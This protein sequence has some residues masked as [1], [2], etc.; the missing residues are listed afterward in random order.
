MSTTPDDIPDIPDKPFC[1]NDCGCDIVQPDW[2]RFGD[3]IVRRQSIRSIEVKTA[4]LSGD[5][6]EGYCYVNLELKF[7]GSGAPEYVNLWGKL[8][9]DVF[10]QVTKERRLQNVL[11]D[12]L[13]RVL[14][15]YDIR[16][17]FME[18]EAR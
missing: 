5:P 14:G 16:E 9:P 7:F 6:K 12:H 13:V 18:M 8:R 1:C 4:D 17:L 11:P 10:A 15:G 2:L 3:L